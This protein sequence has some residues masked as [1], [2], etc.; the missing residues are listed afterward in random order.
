MGGYQ[1]RLPVTRCDARKPC[2]GTDDL[3]HDAENILELGNKVLLLTLF[4]ASPYA[5]K[6]CKKADSRR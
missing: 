3:P 2:G 6:H 4:D 5:P 1:C